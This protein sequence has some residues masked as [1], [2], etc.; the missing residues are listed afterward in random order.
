MTADAKLSEE[1]VQHAFS[2]HAHGA[3]VVAVLRM[4]SLATLAV[5]RQLSPFGYSEE[6]PTA[7]SP[8]HQLTVPQS[9]HQTSR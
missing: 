9:Y 2:K 3:L 8:A 1:R 7:R 6:H 4:I 5:A